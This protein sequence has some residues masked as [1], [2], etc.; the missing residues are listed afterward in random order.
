MCKKTKALTRGK[1]TPEREKMNGNHQNN[2]QD[3]MEL[4]SNK[5]DSESCNNE[6]II[7]NLQD[8]TTSK[9]SLP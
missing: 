3:T 2:M 9:V 6:E 8:L 7:E 1:C 5:L 4:S